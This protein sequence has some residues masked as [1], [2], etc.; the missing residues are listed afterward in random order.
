M[1]VDGSHEL[2]TEFAREGNRVLAA[3]AR[4]NATH[5]TLQQE[6][7]KRGLGGVHN[8]EPSPKV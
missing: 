6:L 4:L 7:R 2:P 5:G 8:F 1:A 3:I